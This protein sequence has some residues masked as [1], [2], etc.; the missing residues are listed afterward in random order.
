MRVGSRMHC[1]VKKWC[2][3][4]AVYAVQHRSDNCRVRTSTGKTE[5]QGK[6][7]KVFLVREKSGK[8]AET[9]EKSGNFLRGKSGDP[10]IRC[11]EFLER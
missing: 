10:V 3:E 9:L 5:K 6:V 11:G 8:I 1:D 7:R 2:I 4:I